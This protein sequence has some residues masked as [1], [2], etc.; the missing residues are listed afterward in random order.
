M[1]QEKIGKFI[2][3][4]RNKLK[5]TQQELADKIGVTDKAVSKWERGKGMPD[6]SL[7]IPLCKAL[8]ISVN[9]LLA[10]DDNVKSDVAVSEYLIN[11]GR[12]NKNKIFSLL[13]VSVLILIVMVLGIFFINNHKNIFVYEIHGKGEYLVY[14]NGALI[15]SNIKNILIPGDVDDNI[16]TNKDKRIISQTLVVGKKNRIIYE[17]HTGE[18]ISEKYGD[19]IIFDDEILDDLYTDLRLIVYFMI[20]NDVYKDEIKLELEQSF[21]NDK[22]INKKSTGNKKKSIKYFVDKNYDKVSL[23]KEFLEKEGFVKTNNILGLKMNVNE[24]SLV[25]FLNDKEAIV[26]N[27]LS[28]YVRYYYNDNE[29]FYT[30]SLFDYD[31]ALEFERN[32]F[33]ISFKDQNGSYGACY[34]YNNNTVGCFKTDTA[35][36]KYSKK[37]EEIAKLFDKYNFYKMSLE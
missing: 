25:K 7:F 33:T 29:I 36:K 18:I 11:E 15:I 8:E 26:V 2:L 34:D 6:Y 9:E 3:S 37:L 5:L 20:G 22:L 24:H 12:R 30:S 31:D 14:R 17:N 19:E 1:D 4:R 16:V 27:Y 28:N 32:W 13:F 21:T 10:G 35:K 23:Y